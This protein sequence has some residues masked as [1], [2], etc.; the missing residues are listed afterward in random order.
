MRAILG[1]DSARMKAVRLII[2]GVALWGLLLSLMLLTDS[3]PARL[4]PSTSQTTNAPAPLSRPDCN[5]EPAAPA[6]PSA[7]AADPALTG[8]TALRFSVCP[9]EEVPAVL[10]RVRL[11]AE[12]PEWL[13]VHCGRSVHLLAIERLDKDVQ[14][15]RVAIMSV[16]NRE[17]SLASR[18]GAVAAGDVDADGQPDLLVPLLLVDAGG[19]PSGGALY[20]LRQR[21]EG[22]LLAPK[23][24]FDAVPGALTIAT[25]DAKPGADLALL[26]LHDKHTARPSELWFVQGGPAPL[27][28]HV[29]AASVGGGVLGAADVDRDGLDDIAEADELDG[30]ARVWLS[31]IAPD[32]ATQPLVFKVPGVREV[33]V[34][35]LDGDGHSD[36]LF[37]GEQIW[38]LLAREGTA[39]EA[40]PIP[41]STA[42]RGLQALDVNADGLLDLVGYSR[43]EFVTLVQR[44]THDF[45]RRTPATVVGN[46]GVL[47]TQFSDFDGD[48]QIDLALLVVAPGPDGEVEVAISL[49]INLYNQSS[50]EV[51]LSQSVRPVRDSAL[52]SRLVL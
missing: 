25:L 20:L 3:L 1:V 36:L 47:A 27:R 30:Q 44:R 18:P 15:R 35:D 45:E 42:L 14:V 19:V 11:Q 17:S 13:A 16:A 31:R 22:G 49:S 26:H 43:P 34:G 5:C 7:V 9:R 21:Q 23:R 29:V 39:P 51:G 52:I 40:L 28:T 50:V 37:S 46:Q 6:A 2:G 33:V 24:L 12:G 4:R 10:S 41:G 48:G 38:S 32:D 8:K